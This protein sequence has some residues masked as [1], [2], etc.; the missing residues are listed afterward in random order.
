MSNMDRGEGYLP[1][2]TFDYS[3]AFNYTS[4]LGEDFPS[5]TDEDHFE[6]SGS[7][8]SRKNAFTD[9][10]QQFAY[11]LLTSLSFFLFLLTAPISSFYC[12]KVFRIT[13][14]DA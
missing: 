4:V 13:Y 14:P 6:G 12:L 7:S 2:P 5:H 11:Y 10:V 8:S 9:P 1:V 3:S